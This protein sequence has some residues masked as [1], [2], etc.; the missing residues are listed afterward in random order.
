MGFGT[1]CKDAATR[2]S[3]RFA[4]PL[5]ALPGISPRIVTVRKSLRKGFR[6]SQALQKGC[7]GCGQL[8]SPR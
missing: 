7:Q 1:P 8:L 2:Q 6:Q 4:L 5:I 3:L